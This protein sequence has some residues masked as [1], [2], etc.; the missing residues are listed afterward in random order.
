MSL[1]MLGNR[2][3]TAKYL[4]DAQTAFEAALTVYTRESHPLQWAFGQNNL[5]DV[6]WNLATHG[7]GKAEFAKA[8]EYFE[9]AKQGFSE[10]GLFAPISITDQKIALVK[11]S[12]E[13]K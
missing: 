2:E 13:A 11:E 1:I 4:P 10:A 7:G 5:G 9:N 3:Q 12:L 6:H 8:L